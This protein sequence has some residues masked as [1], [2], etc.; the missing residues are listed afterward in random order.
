M[1]KPKENVELTLQSVAKDDDDIIKHFN[2]FTSPLVAFIHLLGILDNL[3]QSVNPSVL[4]SKCCELFAS[5]L[6]KI[7]LF[8]ADEL[9]LFGQYNE[10]SMLIKRLKGHWTWYDH[11]VLKALLESSHVDGAMKLLDDFESHIDYAL[12]VTDYP[13][14]TVNHL[15]IPDRSSKYTLLATKYKSD[16]TTK[17]FTLQCLTDLKMKMI[18]SFGITTHSVQLL[19]VNHSLMIFYW[20]IPKAVVP[21]ISIRSSVQKHLEQLKSIGLTE[22][23]VYP[24]SMFVMDNDLTVGPLSYL[25]SQVSLHY[26]S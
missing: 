15:M 11:S 20:L 6:H 24:N 22:V 16:A 10:T 4:V 7:A 21:L 25:Y 3:M 19:A 12:P 8:S 26:I 17:C 1:H 2:H 23:A 18:R 14:P 5:N 9:N 13:I